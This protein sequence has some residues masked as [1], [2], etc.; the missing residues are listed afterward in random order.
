MI[1]HV[2]YR[3]FVHLG[4][5][6][7]VM[8]RFLKESDRDSLVRLFLE[9]RPEDTQFLKQDF[10]D[11]EEVDDLYARIDRQRVL[12]LVAVDLADHHLIACANL[13]IGKHAA[14]HIGELSVFVAE[15]HRDLGL[16]S[17]MVDEMLDLARRAHLRWV[18]GEVVWEQ[19]RL[20]SALRSRGFEIRAV[21]EDFFIRPDGRTHDVVL[22]MRPLLDDPEVIENS[23]F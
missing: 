18:K 15:P 13:H 1:N 7:R 16:G 6:E 10:T 8:L 9:A 17:K 12:S 14:R 23:G 2:S 19:K 21:L 5:G 11:S 4:N 20:I 3:R 22:M